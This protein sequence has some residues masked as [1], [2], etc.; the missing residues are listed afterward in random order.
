[1]KFGAKRKMTE[2]QVV[3]AIELQK[4]AEMTNQ[5]ISDR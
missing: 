4:K 1:M 3:E 2:E 5:K